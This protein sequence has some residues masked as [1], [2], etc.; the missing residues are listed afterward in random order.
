MDIRAV[1]QITQSCF[2]VIS[3]I[4]SDVRA[5]MLLLTSHPTLPTIVALTH[6]LIATVMMAKLVNNTAI[7]IRAGPVFSE[8]T[9]ISVV[10]ED[11]LAFLARFGSAHA[12]I[13]RLLWGLLPCCVDVEQSRETFPD[14]PQDISH[15]QRQGC[16]S[17]SWPLGHC[18]SVFPLLHIDHLF[19]A[20]FGCAVSR[21]PF[22][23][24]AE[25]AA[26][27]TR[28]SRCIL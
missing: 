28:P 9:D 25:Q 2:R 20:I 4:I 17:F 6:I 16:A 7:A 12:A 8:G 14:R 15:L 22:A 23:E 1:R 24:R 18:D 26:G 27:S 11:I 5:I 10:V 3:N 21:S 13:Q 19:K